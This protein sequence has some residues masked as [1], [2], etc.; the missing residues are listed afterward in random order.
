VR[1]WGQAVA[2]HAVGGNV[3]TFLVAFL[4]ERLGNDRA[5]LDD[6]HLDRSHRVTRAVVAQDGQGLAVMVDRPHLTLETDTAEAGRHAGAK[7]VLRCFIL[8]DRRQRAHIVGHVHKSIH[9]YS[10]FS[11][12]L[13]LPF[14]VTL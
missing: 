13:M 4:V 10:P 12:T 1:V 9:R 3:G 8:E 11:Q 7:I 2:R 5:G 6:D 14:K